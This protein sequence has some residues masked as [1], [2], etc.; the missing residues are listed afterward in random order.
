MSV[1][2]ANCVVTG[3]LGSLGSP[4]SCTVSSEHPALARP[5][6]ASSKAWRENLMNCLPPLFFLFSFFSASVAHGCTQHHLCQPDRLPGTTLPLP[7]SRA[8]ARE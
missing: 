5:M 7:L 4:G 1:L 2:S 8:A 6:A 3:S